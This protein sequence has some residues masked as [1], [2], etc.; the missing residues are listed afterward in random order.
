[1]NLNDED[2]NL[3]E[4]LQA[5]RGGIMMEDFVKYSLDMKLL[6]VQ[7]R[8]YFSSSFVLAFLKKKN[9]DICFYKL[10]IGWIDAS[11]HLPHN[12]KKS[13]FRFASNTNITTTQ[14]GNKNIWRIRRRQSEEPRTKRGKLP[15]RDG[16][17][18]FLTFSLIKKHTSRQICCDIKWKRKTKTKYEYFSCH[19]LTCPCSMGLAPYQYA[20]IAHSKSRSLAVAPA[21]TKAEYLSLVGKKYKQGW[22]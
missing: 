19:K 20:D 1:M 14:I 3:Q 9:D 18:C 4:L 11:S 7:V 17:R 22:R 5:G 15:K 6:D 13:S 21:D 16:N 10:I 8:P 12:I 2:P